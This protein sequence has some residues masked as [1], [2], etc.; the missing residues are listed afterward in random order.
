MYKVVE[1]FA[2]LPPN[3]PTYL[4]NEVS[5]LTR[6]DSGT[7]PYIFIRDQEASYTILYTHGNAEDLGQMRPLARLLAEQLHVNVFM[8]DYGG[9]GYNGNVGEC[10]EAATYRDIRAVWEY[11]TEDM[12]IPPH[13]IILYGRSLGT[14]PSVHFASHNRVG[15]VILQSP[16]TSAVAVVSNL[17][18]YLPLTNIFVNSSKIGKIKSPIFILHGNFDKVVPY[19]HGVFLRDCCRSKHVTFWTVEGAG[20]NDIEVYYGNELIRRLNEFIQSLS[21][22]KEETPEEKWSCWSSS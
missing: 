19:D 15:G 5:Y 14:G 21:T 12:K 4:P 22:V 17:L 10:S 16:L 7:I 11:L 1:K 3:P 20:H 18:C 13:K 9:Y 8:Y 6:K 2:F